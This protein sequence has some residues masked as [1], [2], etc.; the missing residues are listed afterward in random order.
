MHKIQKVIIN[1]FWGE[2]TIST[3]FNLDV[4]IFIGRN[5]TGKTTFI[6]LLQAVLTVDLEMLYNLQFD[7]IELILQNG[8]KTKKILVSKLAKDFEYST[9]EYK[10]STSKYELPILSERDL[11]YSRHKTGRLHPKFYRAIEEIKEKLAN[12][13]NISYL[14]VHREN[15]LKIENYR[16]RDASVNSIDLK[17]QE[18]MRELTSYQLQLETEL[19]SL[20]KLFQVHVLKSLLFNKE[21]DYVDIKESIKMKDLDLKNL[22]FQNVFCIQEKSIKN[23]MKA[24]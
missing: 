9:L 12:L 23:L 3:N 7:T 22:K 15:F 17:L 10:I 14:S 6:N 5:G 1:G 16:D 4:T 11:Q 2:Y 19:G 20:S 24:S 21:F 8:N 13:I 18:L